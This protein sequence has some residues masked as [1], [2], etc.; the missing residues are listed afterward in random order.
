MAS[1]AQIVHIE[2][3]GKVFSHVVVHAD[4]KLPL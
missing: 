2:Q 4:R 3:I 1:D